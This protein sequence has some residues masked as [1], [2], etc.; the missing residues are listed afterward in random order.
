[1]RILVTG[2]GGFI[3]SRLVAALENKEDVVYGHHR[4]NGN[5]SDPDALSSYQNIELVYHL[6]AASFVPESWEKPEEY[7]QNNIIST[8]RVLELCRRQK[9]KIIFISTYLYGQPEYLPVDERHPCACI[10]PY[11]LSKKTG[12]DLCRFYSQNFGVD[13]AIVRPFNVYG[14]GQKESYLLPKLHRQLTDIRTDQTDQIEVADLRPR[15]DYIYVSDLVH[16]LVMLKDK[17]SGLEIYNLGSGKSYSVKEVIDM[18]QEEFGTNKKI[19]ET[20]PRRQNEVP[21]CTADIRKFVSRIGDVRLH[22][23]REGIRAWHLSDGQ[24]KETET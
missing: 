11:H 17:V 12:E 2:A 13:A 24:D 22:T 16:M 6:A 10:S 5:L 4:Q 1:M 3:G 7:L 19:V 9:A 20:G 8:I 14:K 15:R 18:M 23:L 21:D